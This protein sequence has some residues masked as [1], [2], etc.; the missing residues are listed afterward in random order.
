MSCSDGEVHPQRSLLPHLQLRVKDHPR[1]PVALHPL[2]LPAA[3]GAVCAQQAGLHLHPGGVGAGAGHA[4]GVHQTS[5]DGGS[6]GHM[7]NRCWTRTHTSC[8]TRVLL[9]SF[10]ASSQ[11]CIE[12][13]LVPWMLARCPRRC[14][15]RSLGLPTASPTLPTPALRQAQGGVWRGGR[16]DRAGRRRHAA[17][18]QPAA[19]HSHVGGGDHGRNG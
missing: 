6:A 17:H 12:Q 3:A 1:P 2:P 15:L 18:A 14:C 19:V 5:V 16:A 9:A 11:P 10:S 7:A 4:P 8:C 13:N